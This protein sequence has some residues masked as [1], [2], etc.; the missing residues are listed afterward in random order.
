L[1]TAVATTHGWTLDARLVEQNVEVGDLRLDEAVAIIDA[2]RP[3]VW[4]P[5]GLPSIE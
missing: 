4:Y 1:A 5:V 3:G 2:T